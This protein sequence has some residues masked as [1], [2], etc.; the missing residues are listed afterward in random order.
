MAFAKIRNSTSEIFLM[1]SS[2]NIHFAVLGIILGATSGYIFAFYQAERNMPTP[3]ARASNVPAGH[4]DVTNEQMVKM[5]EQALAKNPNNPE[6]MT[7]YANFLFDL[8][9]FQDAVDM[10]RRI[11]R[12]QPDNIGVQTDM[13]T[14]LWNLGKSQEAMAAYK[15]SLEADPNNVLTLHNLFVAYVDGTHDL[16]AAAETL[17]HMEKVDPKYA[18]LDSLRKKLEEARQK[19]K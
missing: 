13:G 18:P 7:R 1:F 2:R 10:Y 11:L 16:Q 9:R 5:F 12:L 6:L 15:K 3:A 19:A 8:E 14:A 4:P 17:S